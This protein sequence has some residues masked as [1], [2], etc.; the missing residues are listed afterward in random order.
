MDNG[1][2]KW[3][4]IKYT[5]YLPLCYTIY[6]RLI[7]LN[8]PDPALPK[9]LLALHSS[10]W[11]NVQFDRTVLSNFY[12][13]VRPNFFL[14]LQNTELFF[15]IYWF[16]QNGYFRSFKLDR[17]MKLFCGDNFRQ[18]Y[19]TNFKIVLLVRSGVLT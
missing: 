1:W 5:T 4:F 6:W 14:F 11:P 10:D 2:I 18:K 12:C 3:K 19:S 16:F 9:K 15:T 17:K 13:S 8:W 7:I